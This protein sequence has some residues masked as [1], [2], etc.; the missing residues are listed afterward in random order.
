VTNPANAPDNSKISQ[1]QQDQ[2]REDLPF[3][4]GIPAAGSP[5]PT[6]RERGRPARAGR[7]GEGRWRTCN[8]VL[9]IEL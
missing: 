2:P 5:L 4:A 9:L 3:G 7:P 6:G 1:G 8:V